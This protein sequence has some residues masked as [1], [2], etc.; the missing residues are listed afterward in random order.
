MNLIWTYRDFIHNDIDKRN[1]MT[2]LYNIS[3]RKAKELK[4]FTEIYTNHTEFDG[5]IDKSHFTQHHSIFWDEFKFLPL[6]S[7]YDDFMLIDGDV[8][9]HK[10]FP[11]LDKYD[12]YFDT[13]ERGRK[14]YE[15]IY[16]DEVDKLDSLGI[17]DIFEE[18]KTDVHDIA[19]CGVLYFRDKEFQ[20]LY[21]TKWKRF[22]DFVQENIEHLRPKYCTVIGAQYL[23]TLL[24]NFH[25]KSH[26]YFSNKLREPCEFY[27]HH[28]GH[29]KFTNEK[30]EFDIL[31]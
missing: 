27:V 20:R 17:G 21:Y 28:A 10:E 24:I 11:K 22:R 13:Y 25:K 23:L 18:W 14:N 30:L 29:E 16:K 5:I 4:Y 3:I 19:C 6:S 12:V 8:F 9:I 7:R 2:R 15:Q 1:K 31:I 26:Y